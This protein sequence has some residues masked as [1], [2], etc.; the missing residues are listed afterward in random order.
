[1]SMSQ[2]KNDERF[3]YADYLTWPDGERLE[4]IDG[5]PFAMSPAPG[6][7]HQELSME[8]CR[9]LSNHL[10]GKTCKVYNAPFDVRLSEQVNASDNYIDTVIQPDILVVC[11]KSKVDQRGC[12]GVPDLIIEILSP[13]SAAYDLKVKYDLYQR[14]GVKEYW[15]I[16]PAEHVVQIYRLNDDRLY[17]AAERYVGDDKVAVPLLGDLVIDLKEVFAE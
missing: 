4:L 6:S 12:N 5:V 1:M 16:Y 15:V 3:S 17:G 11:D 10:K 2:Q 8:L 14:F 7:R 9:Q 13:S